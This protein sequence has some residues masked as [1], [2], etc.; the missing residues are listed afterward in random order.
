MTSLPP[1]PA[2]V[3][4]PL[5]FVAIKAALDAARPA[6]AVIDTPAPLQPVRKARSKP[7]HSGGK[8]PSMGGGGAG[9]PPVS[10]LD[11]RLA[12][13]PLT[14]LGNAERFRDR[15]RDK[16]LWCA[17]IG[18]LVWDGRRWAREGADELIKLAEHETVR[19]IQR[20]ALAIR[21]TSDDYEVRAATARKS[22]VWWSDQIAG[23]GRAS[24]ANAKLTPISKQAAPY[25]AVQP[26]AFDADPFL[27][28]CLNGTLVIRRG[29]L[30][31]PLLFRP[32]DP[33]DRITKLAPAAYDPDA[34]CPIYDEFLDFVQ[35][36]D[37]ARRF[38]HQ[39]G[40]L[41][42]TGDVSEQKLVFF[43]GK[44]KNGKSTL[45]DAWATVAGDYGDTLPIETFLDQGRGRNAGQATP[46]LAL[47]PGVRM[48]RTSEPEKGSKLA[49]AMIKL[50]TGGEPIQARHLNCAFFKFYPVF[51]LTLSGNYRPKIDGADEGIWRRVLLVPWTV[52]VPEARRDRLLGEKLRGEASG[53][54]NRL[55][56]GLVDW[57][58]KGLVTPGPVSEATETYRSDSDPLGRFLAACVALKAGSRV[59]A[60]EM[61]RLHS[62][63][64]TANGETQW[65]AKGLSQALRERQFQSK[66]SNVIW[67]LD[68]ELIRQAGDFIDHEGK[69]RMQRHD[70]G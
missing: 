9:E 60:S 41:S 33:A 50:V 59:Q 28:N 68:V 67:W 2:P 6:P 20:E 29:D 36:D 4:V 66:H 65:S 13:Y 62:A 56:A 39:W 8:P 38:L 22:A 5:D 54:L 27:L 53:I 11:R 70:D 43:W 42:L 3:P 24:E 40:G 23:W 10:D 35:P 58:E 31:E 1:K 18:W 14:D 32:H 47:L 51:K 19:A 61:H 7:S 12:Q 15:N 49:E 17:A 44:G 45:V 16:F 46:D 57:I 69:A 64:A 48:L 26:S 37:A 63:W 55:V 30:A 52:T 21:G 34:R 25:L